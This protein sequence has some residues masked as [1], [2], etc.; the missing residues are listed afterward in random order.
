LLGCELRIRRVVEAASPD[1]VEP[2][3]TKM[4]EFLTKGKLVI[5]YVYYLQ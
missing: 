4:T 2:F 3:Q 1:I 5:F